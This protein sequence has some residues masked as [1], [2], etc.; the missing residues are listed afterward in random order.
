MWLLTQLSTIVLFYIPIWLLVL[1]EVRLCAPNVCCAP[2]GTWC[3]AS[4][5]PLPMGTSAVPTP[6]ASIRGPSAVAELL[7]PVYMG[8]LS[9]DPEENGSD[10][11]FLTWSFFPTRPSHSE[12]AS[13]QQAPALA[14]PVSSQLRP[15]EIHPLLPF[16]PVKGGCVSGGKQDKVTVLSVVLWW[17]SLGFSAGLAVPERSWGPAVEQEGTLL[18]SESSWQQSG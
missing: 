8:F 6:A 15:G 4:C 13:C 1:V 14:L 3:R 11:S 9:P 17:L 18:A 5:S 2:I 10:D 7:A 16:T 12:R